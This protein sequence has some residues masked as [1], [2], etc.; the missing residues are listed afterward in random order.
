MTP[1]KIKT[2]L[3]G[4]DH[5]RMLAIVF[6]FLYHYGQLFPHPKWLGTS[7]RFGWTGVDLFF[8]LSGYLI[9]SPLFSAIAANKRLGVPEFF[10]KRSFR[11][12][13][14][15]LCILA[16]YFFIPY[17]REWEGL[18]PA[19]KYL[20]FTQ[21]IGLD[22]LTQR[23]FSHA[24]S[25]C[26]EEQF[27]LL[28][29]FLLLA[30]RYGKLLSK[31]AVILLLLFAANFFCR[32]YCY[33]RIVMPHFDADDGWWYWYRWIYYP[34]FCRLDGLL[35]GVTLAALF[36]FKP[37]IKA[38]TDK[39][40]TLFLLSGIALLTVAYFVCSK[41]DSFAGTVYGFS[42]VSLGYGA[43]LASAVS[44]QSLLFKY[45][46]KFSSVI[47]ALSYSVYLSHKIMIH[48][49][50]DQFSK[51]NIKRDGTWM[52][53][54]CCVSCLLGAMMLRWMVERPFLKWRDVLLNKIKER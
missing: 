21:N 40:G 54:I 38:W 22:L 51:L 39:R 18:A 36:T 49:T 46:L 16:I 7:S 35:T 17:A 20:T 42:L 8:V 3:P 24:W 41:Q 19:W 31:G 13:P 6:V 34:T 9:A 26:I 10:I 27:Y 5:L 14:A 44:K 2:K 33:T 25:L 52:F 48:I 28:F 30:L 50:Q 53:L 32:Y 47:A 37:K 23:T 11:I 15:Y 29:P 4:P 1:D 43:L 12:L 45:N